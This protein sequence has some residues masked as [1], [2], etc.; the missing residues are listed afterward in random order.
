MSP[1]LMLQLMLMV[2]TDQGA[3]RL[4]IPTGGGPMTGLAARIQ[5]I[6]DDLSNDAVEERVVDYVVREIQNGRSLSDAI[7]DPY[8]KNRLSEERVAKVFADP[9][10]MNA[11]EKQ[12]EGFFGR[13]ERDILE[14][15]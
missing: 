13:G 6:L 4:V 7:A 3:V 8:V 1:V 9:E 5:E 14:R 2:K 15:G 10:V 11:L 12:I